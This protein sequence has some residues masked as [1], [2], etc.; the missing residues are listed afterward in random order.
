MEKACTEAS[1]RLTDGVHESV[2]AYL[3]ICGVI[4]HSVGLRGLRNTQRARFVSI[5]DGVE[6]ICEKCFYQC[7]SLSRVT[8][9]ESSSLKLIGKAAFGW[10]GVVEIHIL[11]GVEELCEACFYDCKKLSRVKFGESSSLKLIGNWA[12]SE[13]GVVEIHIPVG[14][15]ELC[16]S[17]FSGCKSLSR[18]TFG[19]YSSLKLIGKAA[20]HSS[21]LRGI[22]IPNSV[23]E[24]CVVLLRVQAS[25]SCEI[26]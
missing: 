24:L 4:D 8:F 10:S 15:E 25:S 21:G 14:V 7:Q 9:G 13:S 1:D 20:F 16:E 26:W 6:E 22:H 12:F 19:Q 5:P 2:A 3:V 23:E 11:D 17:C 18:V